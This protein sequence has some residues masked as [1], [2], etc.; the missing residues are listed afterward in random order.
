[1][2]KHVD[3]T[4]PV[5]AVLYVW[6]PSR[7]AHRKPGLATALSQRTFLDPWSGNPDTDKAWAK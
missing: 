4:R 6:P 1:M 3:T 2:G 7:S 5:D